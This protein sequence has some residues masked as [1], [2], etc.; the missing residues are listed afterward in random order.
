MS[1][2]DYKPQPRILNTDVAIVAKIQEII[3]IV[4]ES[5]YRPVTTVLKRTQTINHKGTAYYA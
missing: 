3:T 1:T 4:A 5:G 2:C